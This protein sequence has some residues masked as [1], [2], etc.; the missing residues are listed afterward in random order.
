MSIK[1]ITGKDIDWIKKA[2]VT[3]EYLDDLRRGPKYYTGPDG[4]K[5]V[6]IEPPKLVDEKDM[7]PLDMFHEV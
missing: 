3:A 6:I 7:I 2:K 5:H 4:L 1:R